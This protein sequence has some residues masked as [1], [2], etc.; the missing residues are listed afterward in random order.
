METRK[1]LI[2]G[3]V[4]GIVFLILDIVFAIV[5]SPIL[6]PYASLA[7]WKNP[8]EFTAGSVF[9]II[10]GLMLAGVYSVLY[11]GIPGKGLKK[12]FNY[13]L[14]VGLFRVVM[15]AFS[16]FVMIAIPTEVVLANLLS[17]YVE[18]VLLCVILSALYEKF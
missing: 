5:A 9:D 7:V 8:P 16:N 2:A 12:G 1:V 10:N 14:I 15:S 4:T 11:K 17:G 13:G 3:F 18:I 6:A